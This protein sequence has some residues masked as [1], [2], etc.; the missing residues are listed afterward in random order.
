MIAQEYILQ[1]LNAQ[2]K[3]QGL[4]GDSTTYKT[5][6]QSPGAAKLLEFFKYDHLPPHLQEISRVICE[7]AF[8]L[9]D[10]MPS[11][12][13]ATVVLRKLLEAKDCAVRAVLSP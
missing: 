9:A 11:N 6:A 3:A 1:K 13:E 8:E 10:T 5:A 7:A 2:A 12:A 4:A